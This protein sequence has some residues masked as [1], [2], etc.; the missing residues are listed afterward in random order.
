MT[1][2]F[3]GKRDNIRPDIHEL[4]K[5]M[6]KAG[7]N[8]PFAWQQPLVQYCNPL[9]TAAEWRITLLSRQGACAGG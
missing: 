3:G 9:C 8:P 4:Q 7:N 6:D 2:T 1:L 5:R